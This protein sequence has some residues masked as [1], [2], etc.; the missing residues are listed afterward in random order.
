MAEA[1]SQ[2]EVTHLRAYTDYWL[3]ASAY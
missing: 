3:V 2:K 1:S